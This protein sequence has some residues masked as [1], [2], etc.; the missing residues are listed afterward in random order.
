MD[1]IKVRARELLRLSR[2]ELKR[3]SDALKLKNTEGAGKIKLAVLIA[4]KEYISDENEG[5]HFR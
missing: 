2:Y 3:R 4:V 1:T 5:L